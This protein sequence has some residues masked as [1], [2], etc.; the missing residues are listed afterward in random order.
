MDKHLPH[1][2]KQDNDWIHQLLDEQLVGAESFDQTNDDKEFLKKE[3]TLL[4]SSGV[5]TKYAGAFNSV[6][7]WELFNDRIAEA[8]K[9]RIVSMRSRLLKYAAILAIP[10]LIGAGIY[11]LDKGTLSNGKS[12]RSEVAYVKEK[13]VLILEDGSKLDA[14]NADKINEANGIHILRKNNALDYSK[15]KTST[16]PAAAIYHTLIIPRGGNYK[17]VLGDGTEIWVN[18][19]TKIKYQVNFG[20]TTTRAVFLENGEAY[21]KVTKNP[22]QPF[23]VHVKNKMNVQVLGTSFNVNTYEVVTRTTLVEGKVQVRLNASKKELVLTPGQQ[24]RFNDQTDALDKQNVDVSSF[25]AWKDGI[26][27]FEQSTFETVMEE[28]GRSYDYNVEFASVELKQLH[29]NGS[30]EKTA[31]IQELLNIIQ[32]TT[33]VKFTIKGRR[34]IVEKLTQN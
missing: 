33:H 28:I 32:T 15:T 3:N 18:A 20:S 23:I 12:N 9:G 1:K 22:K 19:D 29:Y 31:T 30:V 10:V 16:A 34:I 5:R 14:E 8:G 27:A 24:A 7:G 11:M 13:A 6:D 25:V 21:F 4:E 2:I 17:L 26:F